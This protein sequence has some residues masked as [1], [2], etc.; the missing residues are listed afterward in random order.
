MQPFPRRDYEELSTEN[1]EPWEKV[2]F[3]GYGGQKSLGITIGGANGGFMFVCAKT[4]AWW[5][6]LTR[7]TKL[8]L[9]RTAP[10]TAV[11]VMVATAPS[12][13]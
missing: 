9:C 5:K 11:R 10:I 8:I 2:Y 7:T 12:A 4:N 6:H 13:Y 1:L 3:D